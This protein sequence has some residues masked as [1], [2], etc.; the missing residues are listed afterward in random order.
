MDDGFISGG[1]YNLHEQTHIP[2]VP[3]QNAN[4]RELHYSTDVLKWYQKLN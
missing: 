4:T 1:I 2:V 3:V